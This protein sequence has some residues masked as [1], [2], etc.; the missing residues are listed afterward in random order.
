MNPVFSHSARCWF[1]RSR[2]HKSCDMQVIAQANEGDMMRNPGL[3]A[4]RRKL[5]P[6][7]H[8]GQSDT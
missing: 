4:E 2:A 5:N 3:A 8:K 7:R 6:L 1:C